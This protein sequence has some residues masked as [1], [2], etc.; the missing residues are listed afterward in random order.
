MIHQGNLKVLTLIGLVVVLAPANLA[1]PESASVLLEKAIYTEETVGDLDAA[2]DLYEKTIEEA[3][4]NRAYAAEALYRLGMCHAK[5]GETAPAQRAYRKLIERYPE[6]EKFVSL[7]KAQLI[8]PPAS[9]PAFLPISQVVQRTLLEVEDYYGFKDCAIDLDTGELITLPEDFYEQRQSENAIVEW[10]KQN[11]ID[12]LCQPGG[13][14]G[15]LAGIEMIVVAGSEV[16]WDT[17]IE[18]LRRLLASGSPSSPAVMSAKGQP[19]LLYGFKTLR[20]SLGIL[21]IQRLEQDVSPK[22][23]S[24]RYKVLGYDVPQ[25]QRIESESMATQ[26]WQ[27]WRERQLEEAEQLFQ[28]AVA[29]DPSNDSAWNG[30]GWSRSNQGRPEAARIAFEQCIAL[31]PRHAGALNGLGWIA[32]GEGDVE[33]AIRY[34]RQAVEEAPMATAALEGLTRTHMELQQYDEAARYYERWLKVEPDNP[35]A[36]K[37]LEKSRQGKPRVEIGDL[38][39]LIRELSHPAPGAPPFGALNEIIDLGSPAV[40]RLIEEMKTNNDWQIPKA[41]GA[42]G[43]RRAMLPLIEKLE[44]SDGSPMREVVAEA[45]GLLTGKDFGADAKAWR[46][47]WDEEGNLPG[48]PENQIPKE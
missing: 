3:E 6:E 30:L 19:P 35:E 43:D 31:N 2:I 27:R 36:K 32:K 23:L 42:I 48:Q 37:G 25:E 26:G 7:A 5:K 10:L 28:K 20:G 47:W 16:D 44:K 8:E 29:I 40:P 15:G 45:L 24:M 12:A 18:D 39:A 46:R 14:V 13:N 4:A 38:P 11:G 22:Q 34:W 21:E 33:A 41:L 9:P 1:W 17:P